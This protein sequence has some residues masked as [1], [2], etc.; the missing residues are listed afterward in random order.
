MSCR[1]YYRRCLSN[2]W[3]Y[4]PVRLIIHFNVPSAIKPFPQLADS[5]ALWQQFHVLTDVANKLLCNHCF[6][7]P[8]CCRLLTFFCSCYLLVDL[9][10]NLSIY[11]MSSMSSDNGFF[12]TLIL[13]AC[14]LWQIVNFLSTLA[15]TFGLSDI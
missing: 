2:Q 15:R 13:L 1:F 3:I 6:L 7:L 4:S 9:N 14:L 5:G 10:F 8:S 11:H 12:P